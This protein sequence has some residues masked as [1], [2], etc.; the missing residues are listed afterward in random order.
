MSVEVRAVVEW[1]EALLARAEAEVEKDVSRCTPRTLRR[2]GTRERQHSAEVDRELVEAR[3][4]A[5]QGRDFRHFEVEAVAFAGVA[6]R[7]EGVAARGG[8]RQG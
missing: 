8:R 1:R 6:V 2:R 3:G 4:P 5:R 7:L